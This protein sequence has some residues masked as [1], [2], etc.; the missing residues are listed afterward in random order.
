[1]TAARTI[2]PFMLLLLRSLRELVLTRYLRNRHISPQLHGD[3]LYLAAACA[4]SNRGDNCREYDHAFYV[5]GLLSYTF[6]NR[7]TSLP[8]DNA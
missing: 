5:H 2:A 8:I 1:M 4:E 3:M 6:G 7:I